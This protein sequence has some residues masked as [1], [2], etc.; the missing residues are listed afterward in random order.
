[1]NWIFVGLLAGVICLSGFLPQICKGFK[2]KRMGDLSYCLMGLLAVGMF[3][4][5]IYGVHLNDFAIIITNAI[6]VSL[7][8]VLIAMKYYYSRR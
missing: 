7:N 3:L 4:W 5:L 1:M 8:I 2:T 6:G